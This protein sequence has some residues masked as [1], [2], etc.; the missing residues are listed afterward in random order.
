[1]LTRQ[2]RSELY[3][4]VPELS[5]ANYDNQSFDGDNNVVEDEYCRSKTF[6][7][8]CNTSCPDLQLYS[9][10]NQNQNNNNNIH[11]VQNLIE[12]LGAKLFLGSNHNTIDNGE[13]STEILALNTGNLYDKEVYCEICYRPA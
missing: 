1:M 2:S 9:G 5:I 6:I 12:I 8:V 13:H 10:D 4:S 7:K 11:V 3:S